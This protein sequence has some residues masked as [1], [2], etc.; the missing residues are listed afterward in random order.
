MKTILLLGFALW[1]AV[2]VAA[3]H[4]HARIDALA[5]RTDGLEHIVLGTEPTP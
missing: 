3:L 2:I 1:V 4:I 5:A